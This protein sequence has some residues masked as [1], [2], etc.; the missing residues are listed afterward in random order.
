MSGVATRLPA[1]L[2][3]LEKIASARSRVGAALESRAALPAAVGLGVLGHIG[4]QKLDKH[5][6]LRKQREYEKTQEKTAISHGKMNI[7]KERMGRRSMSVM[8]MLK[9]D[10]K[11]ALLKK[12]ADAAGSAQNVRGDSSD[13]V[14]SAQQPRRPGETPSKVPNISEEQKTGSPFAAMLRMFDTR[15]KLG[16]VPGYNASASPIT[17][18]PTPTS[19]AYAEAK[20]PKRKGDVPSKE[21]QNVVDRRDQRDNATTVTGLGQSSTGIGAMNSPGEHP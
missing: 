5:L 2:D 19:S 7:S 4:E 6:A 21:D 10:A 11:G 14:R 17:A 8:T 9:R 16:Q 18:G 12:H 13:D 20:V 1:F 3:E 15:M